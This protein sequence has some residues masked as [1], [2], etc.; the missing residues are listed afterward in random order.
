MAC[1][2]AVKVADPELASGSCGMSTSKTA[3]SGVAVR[4]GKIRKV[5]GSSH[6]D[7]PAGSS[8]KA[9]ALL[10]RSEVIS[11]P[12]SESSEE[13][14]MMSAVASASRWVN[15]CADRD[16]C[17]VRCLVFFLLAISFFFFSRS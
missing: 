12:M 14:S 3:S 16:L 13:G 17:D 2:I 6:R 4:F 1:S 9:P 15:D 11:E 5:S 7:R 8:S 10:T